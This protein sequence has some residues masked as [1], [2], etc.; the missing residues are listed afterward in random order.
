MKFETESRGEGRWSKDLNARQGLR[1]NRAVRSGRISY[2]PGSKWSRDTKWF[3]TS[4]GSSPKGC[5]QRLPDISKLWVF[6]TL[7]TE[8]WWEVLMV[9]PM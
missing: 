1:I 7:Q 5:C 6:P 8:S 2:S 4:I 9:P 3:P